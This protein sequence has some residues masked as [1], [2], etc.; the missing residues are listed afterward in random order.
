VTLTG[1]D[2][3]GRDVGARAGRAVKP[4]VLELGGS[5]P[6]VVLPTADLD[7]AATTGARARCINN[8]Q[9]CIAA[10]RFIVHEDVYDAFVERLTAAMSALRVG[11]P[12]LESTE[13]GPLATAAIR[14]EVDDQ[15][16][17]TIAAG[18]RALCGGTRLD[19]A[20]HFYPP[21]VLVDVPRHAAAGVEEVFGPVAAVFRAS[22]ADEALALANDTPFG[23]GAS[24]WTR[25]PEEAHRFA[26]GIE[27]GSVFINAMMA[28]D[29]RFPFGGVKA[30]GI[31][32]ELAREGLRAFVNVKTVRGTA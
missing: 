14:D 17:R 31:G 12:I 1:S 18:A 29:P 7:A 22:S 5:D 26:R 25:D 6:F 13:V 23:L 20:G 32:R 4:C 9:S 2:A 15:V 28:S 16:Q 8:G 19:G 30:S 10:K 3:A 27:A 24:V 21:T 11:D